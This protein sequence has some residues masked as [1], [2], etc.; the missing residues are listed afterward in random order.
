MK[1][2]LANALVLSLILSLVMPAM[3]MMLDEDGDPY[4]CEHKWS[5]W[6]TAQKGTCVQQGSRYRQ[7]KRCGATQ[8]ERTGYGSHKWSSWKVTEESTCV[9]K[10]SRFRQCKYCGIIDEERIPKSGHSYGKWKVTKEATCQRQGERTRTCKYCDNK[11]TEKFYADHVYGAWSV[12]REPTCT[13][14][15]LR[16][17]KCVNCGEAQRQ[18]IDKVPHSFEW[19][20]ITEATDH[21]AGERASVCTVC[22]YRE[23]AQSYD[24]EGTLRRKD[25]GE[26]VRHMQQLLVEQGYL[27]AGG[28]DGNFGGGTEKALAQ[29]QRDRNL[30]PDGIGWPQT[31]A[32]LEHD[33][34]PWE[35]VKALTRSGSG[36]RV[37]VCRGC[38]FEQRETL[39]AGDVI[40]RGARG[41]NV[42][43]LQQLLKQVGYDAGGFDG[44]YGRKLDAAF[45]TFDEAHG[46]TF[47]AGRVRPIDVDAL[48][49][50]WLIASGEDNWKG[51][52]DAVNLA[53]T[54]TPAGEADDSG[55]NTYTWSLTNLGD[56]K[57]TF[58]ALLLT[59]GNSPD[60]KEDN[61]VMFIGGEEMKPNSKNS[62]SGSFTAS[63][64]WGTGNLNF[65]ALAVND[66]GDAKWLSNVVTFETTA[67]EAARTVAPQARNIDVNHLEDGV[68]PVAF[69]RG[70]VSRGASGIYM[71]AVHIFTEDWY[72][73]ADVNALKP[74][75]TLVADGQ[76]IQVTS[77]EGSDPVRVNGGMD[78][79]DGVDLIPVPNT[80]GYRFNGLSDVSAYT[81]HGVTTLVIA[82]SA[83][84]T[85]S[86]DIDGAPVEAGYDG[87]VEAMQSSE[88]D[89]FDQYNTTVRIESG[90]VVEI[91]RV[92][93]P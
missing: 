28:A 21:S 33:F 70:D 55:V 45:N 46:L 85:D 71:N 5:K 83:T 34:G 13:E 8:E 57:C 59:Y 66:R 6:H 10:G 56:G 37:R 42:R 78:A 52:D 40:E 50:A 11:Q 2:L 41:E 63:P 49:N 58:V 16:V 17:R 79:E 62:A 26:A 1:K 86:S 54:V 72:D 81:E 9:R 75:D 73:I 80:N 19:Q 67:P 65:A 64:D 87:I 89:T 35:T 77:V 29:Y 7:C 22:G 43:A 90:K 48:V 39:E 84:Y 15:G 25:K 93:V 30:N 38:G 23:K 32:D 61:L 3:A 12:S 14:T 69:D 92:Y 27:N 91:R 88:L 60:F 44:I 47:E 4:Y 31:L 82:P 24:P 68:Y 53:L 51:E 36:E 74:G 20:I 18:T 76:T